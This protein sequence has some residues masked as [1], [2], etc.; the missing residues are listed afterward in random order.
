MILLIFFQKL[1]VKLNSRTWMTLNSS[2]NDFSS[3][4]ISAVSMS[5]TAS[6]TSV[7][8]ITSTV[9]FYQEFTHFDGWIIPSTQK[10]NT[11]P[12]LFSG[13]SKIQFVADIWYP[14]S[15]SLLRPAYV[16]FLKTGQWNSNFQTSQTCFAIK[17]NKMIN[18][19]TQ[20]PLYKC[21]ENSQN[22]IYQIGGG[23]PIP[24]LGW[25]GA[26]FLTILFYNLKKFTS[27][28]L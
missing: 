26:G 8:S 3:L 25:M 6:I 15:R 18:C 7:A 19:S 28:P 21:T 24:P 5:C 27:R 14:F 22:F 13:S 12:I 4:R 2:V 23:G 10:T 20:G 1:N 17:F 11:S 16:T 9:S